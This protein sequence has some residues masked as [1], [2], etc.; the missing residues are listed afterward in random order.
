MNKL[1][2]KDRASILH[3]LCEGS[4]V[5]STRR[6]VDVSINTVLK[7]VL[8]AGH[9]CEEFH[10]RMV[11]DV[12]CER[13]QADE[14]WTFIYAK[15]K[16]V[17]TAKRQDLAVGSVWTWIVLDVNSRLAVSWLVGDRSI[18][19]ARTLMRD[20][21]DRVARERVQLTTDGL[22]AYEQAVKDAFGTDIDYAM[23]VKIFPV[24][25]VKDRS[26][27]PHVKR[28][29]SGHRIAADPNN[30]R[31]D[32]QDWL[33]RSSSGH[34]WYR[35]S[36]NGGVEC[37]CPDFRKG[38]ECKHIFAVGDHDLSKSEAVFRKFNAL[39]M[40]AHRSHDPLKVFGT[41]ILPARAATPP[42]A[43]IEKRTVIGNPDLAR[44]ST[45]Y[46]ERQNRTVRMNTRRYTNDV[47]S[48]SKSLEY[49]RCALAL[50]YVYYN[51]V[52]IHKT[53]RVTPAIAAGITD[54]LWSM[55]DIVGLIDARAGPPKK[56][57]PYKPRRPNG[58]ISN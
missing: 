27:P 45:S 24:R 33:V 35:V 14:F 6:L 3:H 26:R 55:Q 58:P 13:L 49:H 29:L 48:F 37:E 57:G 47:D 19:C 11:R 21:Y 17:P 7:L 38:N 41:E 23:L 30:F 40:E 1:S 8:D 2:V 18:E 44:V 34:L 28:R 42:K 39:I 32:G 15:E 56:R 36:F 25:R 52:R 16:N 20:V 4:S 46:V 10:D 51:F 54:R 31:R 43:R 53:L 22:Q 12:K 50:W 5:Q 9:A